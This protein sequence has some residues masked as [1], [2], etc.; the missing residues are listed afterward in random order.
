MNCLHSIKSPWLPT[1]KTQLPLL[2]HPRAN[3]TWLYQCCWTHTLTQAIKIPLTSC[4]DFFVGGKPSNLVCVFGAFTGFICLICLVG[5]WSLDNR[6]FHGWIKH[7]FEKNSHIHFLHPSHFSS[8]FQCCFSA[9]SAKIPVTDALLLAGRKGAPREPVEAAG[10]HLS[11][12][13]NLHILGGFW[14]N[15]DLLSG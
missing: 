7:D 1:S 10:G 3:R 6:C 2:L 15:I 13:L 5:C 11:T 12:T 14:M 9:I 8:E 4:H